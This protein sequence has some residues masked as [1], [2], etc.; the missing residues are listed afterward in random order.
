MKGSIARALRKA[1]GYKPNADRSY[2]YI[3][4]TRTKVNEQMSPRQMYKK[5][6]E[7]FNAGEI[8]TPEINEPLVPTPTPIKIELGE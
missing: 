3:A 4:G 7:L 5:A 1:V 6:K 2:K 8:N